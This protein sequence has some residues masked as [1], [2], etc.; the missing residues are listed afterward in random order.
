MTDR[1]DTGASIQFSGIR[2]RYGSTVALDEL[3]LD[4]EPGEFVSLLGPS[5]SGKSTTLNILAGLLAPDAGTVFIG[6]QDVTHL[7][8]NRRD[9]AMVFQNYALYPHMSV[10]ENLAFPLQA[11]GRKLGSDAIAAKVS[12]VA[13]TLGISQLLQRQPRE[14]SGGQQQRVALGRAMVRDPKV[15]LLDEPLSNLDARLRLRMR[16]DLKAL[17]Q[18]LCSTIIYVTH[19]QSEAMSLSDRVAIYMGGK[20]Q[21]FAPPLEIYRHPVNLFVAQFM[22]EREMNTLAGQIETSERGCV[23]VSHNLRLPLEATATWNRLHGRQVI[24]GIRAEGVQ[25]ATSEEQQSTPAKVRLVEHAGAE[26][27]FFAEAGS[28][29]FCGRVSADAGLRAGDSIQLRLLP[30][31]LFLFDAA[32]GMALVQSGQPVGNAA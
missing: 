15:F 27:V 21:Q 3:H 30:N 19:D 18:R 12:Q 24:M 20:L 11:P 8:P 32:T 16:R 7:S 4:I 9:I 28:T 1:P 5:G 29:E 31:E 10:A 13:E 2:K 25:I 22:G 17:H 14:I 6:G 23:M 26:Q